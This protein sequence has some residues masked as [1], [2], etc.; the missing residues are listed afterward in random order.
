MCD[1]ITC[2]YV[3]NST[4]P[5]SFLG[6]AFYESHEK[7]SQAGLNNAQFTKQQNQHFLFS[8]LVDDIQIYFKISSL[9]VIHF[10][11]KLPC[12]TNSSRRCFISHMAKYWLYDLHMP[13]PKYPLG[14]CTCM[15]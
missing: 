12:G 11:V 1:H 3:T 5:G 14:I 9:G 7:P 10:S 6:L 2:L 13:S 8:S 4:I 15:C